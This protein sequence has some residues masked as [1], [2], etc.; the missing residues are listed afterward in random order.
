MPGE[1]KRYEALLEDVQ[2]SSEPL[3]ASTKGWNVGTQ[4]GVFSNEHLYLNIKDS[5]KYWLVSPVI[6]MLAG[7]QLTF[8]LALT[9][10]AGATP[11]AVTA[12][13]QNDDLFAVLVSEDGG[14]SWTELG[15]WDNQ[16]QGSSFDGI[17]TEGQTVKFDLS[18]YANKSILLAFY[19][20]STEANGDNNLHISNVAI[21]LI[22]ACERPL[23]ITVGGI[24]GSAASISW[25]ADVSPVLRLLSLGTQTGTVS[26]STA[27]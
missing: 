9:T 22:P 1:W 6:E 15:T 11:T 25:D 17:N 3:V 26:G 12:G 20:E 18:E 7:Y 19:G 24:T 8:D 10:K 16:G 5:T 23:S 27:T 14:A 13:E 2:Q 4:N 21:D